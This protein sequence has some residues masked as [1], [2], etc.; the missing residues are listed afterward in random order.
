MTKLF[1]YLSILRF[2]F[3]LYFKLNLKAIKNNEK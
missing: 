3:L 2:I 1:F